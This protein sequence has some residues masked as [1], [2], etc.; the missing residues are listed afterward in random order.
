M[1]QITVPPVPPEVHDPL[2][3]YNDSYGWAPDAR[4][5]EET[6]DV[7]AWLQEQV[8]FTITGWNTP[9]APAVGPGGTAH[10]GPTHMLIAL[11]DGRPYEVNMLG[12]C[13]FSPT[14][15]YNEIYAVAYKKDAP[16]IPPYPGYFVR[17]PVGGEDPVGE[18]W[19]EHSRNAANRKIHHTSPAWTKEKWPADAEFLRTDGR[20]TLVM[21]SSVTGSWLTSF[22]VTEVYFWQKDYAK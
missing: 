16:Q 1:N 6:F 13:G 17:H 10:R 20:Y 18:P 14:V 4:W 19:P 7:I 3:L 8:P 21:T 5:N 22:K 2:D 11:P 9:L 15:A 12:V